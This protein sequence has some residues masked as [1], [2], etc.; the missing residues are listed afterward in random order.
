MNYLIPKLDKIL[1]TTH[2]DTN[3]LQDYIKNNLISINSESLGRRCGDGRDSQNIAEAVFGADLGY[4]YASIAAIHELNNNTDIQTVVKTVIDEIT[5]DTSGD[6][7]I[8][9]DNHANPAVLAGG[10]GFNKQARNNNK[11]GLK[12]EDFKIIDTELNKAKEHGNLNQIVY[13]GEHKEQAVIIVHS[14]YYSVKANNSESNMS[15]FVVQ[16]SLIQQ[17]LKN[18]ALALSKM[19]GTDTD[20]VLK[21]LIKWWGIQTEETRLAL[22][23]D[24]PVYTV[25]I[26]KDA[27]IAI[28]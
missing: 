19:I 11:F 28:A 3:T 25:T 26:D 7:Y 12:E 10:C 15:I 6:I 2:M 22:A 24:K 9:T 20:T 23:T 18:I 14:E 8:H 16:N 5:K 17:R 21:T 13:T 1:Y 27:M 4:I